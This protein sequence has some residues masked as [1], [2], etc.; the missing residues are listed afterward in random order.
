MHQV[1][2]RDWATVMAYLYLEDNMTEDAQIG[3]NEKQGLTCVIDTD[4]SSAHL[5][6]EFMG[7][8]V[9]VFANA[10][11]SDLRYAPR[12]LP[13]R[14]QCHPEFFVCLPSRISML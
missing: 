14:P 9:T 7:T 11:I 1:D 6:L 3:M 12:C 4:N 8:S 2:D 5:E 13:N 10:T